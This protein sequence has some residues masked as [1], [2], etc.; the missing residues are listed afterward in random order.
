MATALLSLARGQQ[1]R[2]PLAMTGELTL[3]G[4]VLA[5][6]GIREKIIAARRAGLREIILPEDVRGEFTELPPYVHKGMRVH[7]VSEFRE[8]AAIVFGERGGRARK[9]TAAVDP[10]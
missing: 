3:T 1:I 4:R 8:V 5:V 10:A 7:F 9:P 2:R 6:G